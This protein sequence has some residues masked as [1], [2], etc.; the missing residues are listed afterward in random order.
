[1][2]KFLAVIFL[3][4]PIISFAQEGYEHLS[5]I[6]HGGGRTYVVT[7]RGLAAVGLNPAL[8]GYDN[9]KTFEIQV[10]P[11]SAYGLDAGPSFSDV[12]ALSGVFNTTINHFN[13]SSLSSIANLLSNGKLSG[14]GDAEV[15]GISY[16]RPEI[17]TF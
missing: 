9:D 6:A 14:R 16:R 17:G 15:L 7:S 8:L 10:F 11:L 3:F 1:F 13:D 5:P 12:N 2:V 4:S